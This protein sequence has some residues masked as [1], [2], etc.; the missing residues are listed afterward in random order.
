MA[1]VI[2]AAD[3]ALVA[4]GGKHGVIKGGAA[5]G[6]IGADGDVAEHIQGFL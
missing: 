6:I 1:G 3:E 2:I 4:E 5:C